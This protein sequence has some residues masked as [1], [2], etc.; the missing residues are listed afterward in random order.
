M[1]IKN[2]I[3]ECNQNNYKEINRKHNDFFVIHRISRAYDEPNKHFP[4]VSP[5]SDNQLTGPIVAE[6]FTDK[7]RVNRNTKHWAD[8]PGVVSNGKM[9][10]HL[11]ITVS[12]EIHQCKPLSSIGCHAAGYNGRSIG[13]AIV[14]NFTKHKPTNNQI[15][16]TGLLCRLFSECGYR[17]VAHDWLKNSSIDINKRCPGPLFPLRDIIE[18]NEYKLKSNLDNYRIKK[19]IEWCGFVI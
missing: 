3:N 19:A 11:V 10:Y 7:R 2:L 6:W 18:N 5:V 9:P 1:L 4:D 16:T 14:G 17:V 13:L 15:D 12:G 8:R